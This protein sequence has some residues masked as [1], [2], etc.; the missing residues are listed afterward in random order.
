MGAVTPAPYEPLCADA[1]DQSQVRRAQSLPSLRLGEAHRE[2]LRAPALE[3]QSPRLFE[4]CALR[5]ATNR[6]AAEASLGSFDRD[7]GVLRGRGVHSVPL[8]LGFL[9]EA[10]A[11]E[12]LPASPPLFHCLPHIKRTTWTQRKPKIRH[13]TQSHAPPLL[14]R[15]GHVAQEQTLEPE[16]CSPF[17]NRTVSPLHSSTPMIPCDFALPESSYDRPMCAGPCGAR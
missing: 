17:C 4:I 13:L 9:P 10:R 14:Q 5:S 11:R 15:A 16:T 8:P 7:H 3:A 6:V 12:N 1:Q 2:V